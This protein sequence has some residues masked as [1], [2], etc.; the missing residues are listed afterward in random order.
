MTKQALIVIG[1]GYG[2]EGKG[3]TVDYLTRKYSAHTVI[4]FNG[5]SQA[6]HQVVTSS[7]VTHCF[8]Q[9]GSGTLVP[10]VKSYLSHYMAV[11]PLALLKENQVLQEKGIYDALSR[12][13]VDENCL[14]TTPFHKIINQM[15]EI[16]RG[17]S[18]HGSCGKGVG[19][20]ILDSYYLKDKALFIKDLLDSKIASQK[21]RFLWQIKLDLAEQIFSQH[22][23]EELQPYLE[24]LKNRD[25]V[26]DLVLA[27]KD[28]ISKITIGNKK[29]LSEILSFDGTV[30]F[31]G[32]QGALLDFE[33]GFYPYVTKTCT[34]FD[35]ASSLLKSLSYKGIIKN[36][37]VL[38]AYSTR[39]GR[40][41][42]VTEDE[43][44]TKELPDPYNKVNPWQS[45]FRVGWFD[46]VAAEYACQIAK[47]INS[48]AITNLDR[49]SNIPVWQ[50]CTGYKYRGNNTGLLNKFFELTS[51]SKVITKI[52]APTKTSHDYQKQLGEILKDCQ[53]VY[54][55][56]EKENKYLEFISK[57]LNI[58]INILSYSNTA[59]GKQEVSF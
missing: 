16:S 22:Q 6:A 32:A 39:H 26:E 25:Y 47:N 33:R 19:Q 37:G 52:K 23:N 48:L 9:F 40:G 28:F 49:L 55:T 4:R 53:A 8:A 59:E 58:P 31:E 13:I 7:S 45:V 2:D 30:V 51:D 5:G 34:T 57:N 17:D 38:R 10:G 29:L 27:Y 54:Q 12:L 44:L 36:I 21:L 15:Q 14:V 42:F 1:L 3:T 35:N 46:L 56:F 43:L 20:T 18:R 50:I 41:P 24:R 11:D